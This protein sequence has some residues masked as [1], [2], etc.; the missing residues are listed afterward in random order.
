MR[1]F[2]FVLIFSC[3]SLSAEIPPAAFEVM[4]PMSQIYHPVSTNNPEA[5]KSFDRG[6]TNIFAYNHDLAFWEFEKAS[7]LDPNLAMAYWGMALARGQNVNEDVTPER[8]ILSY[9]LIQQALKLFP[10]ASKSEQDYINALATR[11]TNDPK[12]NLIPYRFTYRDA[13]KKLMEKYPEDLDA[14]TLYAES[15]LNL[16]P[17]KWWTV[18]GKANVGTYEA[19]DVLESVLRRNPNH[20]GAN[21]FNIHAWEE[22]PFPERALMSAYRL[23]YLNP[24]SGHL[25][26]MP[27]HIFLQTGDYSTALK[28]SINALTQDRDYIKRFG[29]DSG[30]YPLH[31]LTHNL[32]VYARTYMLME[33]Y[34]NAIKAAL[35]LVQFVQP[36]IHNTAAGHLENA[37][38]VPI[39]IYL[40]FHKWN[41]LLKYPLQADSPS[42]Q[43]YW[44]F[45][46]AVAYA[47]LGNFEASQ[48]ER[49]KMLEFKK[50]IKPEDTIDMNPSTEVIG[51]GEI[52][53]DATIARMRNKDSEY[54]DLLKKGTIIQEKF[55]Y[56]EPPVWYVP[57]RQL[58]GFAYLKQGNFEQAEAAFNNVLLELQRNGRTLYGL[59]LSLKGQNRPI[60]AYWVQREAN[61]A[62]KNATV[63]LDLENVMQ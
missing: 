47:S 25:L 10:N 31:Y 62:L 4:P 52:M 38:K 50:Q 14:A 56:G 51:L 35:E 34:D 42:M 48:K 41:E 15:I 17:W 32:H 36:H 11:Y 60:D 21:H 40:Y 1:N 58:L 23:T 18:D 57:V 12:T 22:S 59:T 13:M 20:V 3:V 9:N 37:L 46:R 63:R 7:K 30:T 61:A 26:H 45:A 29:L 6:L 2:L 16:D 53:L 28:T 54:I 5:Q 43:A 49:E 27:T 33:D 55:F 39:D 8:E 44:H 19:I 24:E